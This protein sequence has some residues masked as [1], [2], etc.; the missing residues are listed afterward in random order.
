MPRQN[1][2]DPYGRLIATEARG[3]L[4][5]NR[6]R[7]HDAEGGI[8][9]LWTTRAWIACRLAFKDRHRPPM[10]PGRYTALFF[11]DE[12]TALAAGH[13]PCAE[14]RRDDYLRFKAAWV[15]GN[16][17]LGLT[18]ATPV[19][20]LD[21]ILQRD[22]VAGPPLFTKVFHDAAIDLL[23]DGV[24]IAGTASDEAWLV[25]EDWLLRWSPSGYD[26]AR[27]RPEARTVRVLTPRSIV[28]AIDA[29]YRPRIHDS[30]S[31]LAARAGTPPP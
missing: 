2:V 9:R 17:S 22:R 28:R 15:E 1:R 25:R 30:A 24:F 14:C 13:R 23:P 4:M 21:A 18:R 11:L 27:P 6:G 20:R 8:R 19:Q 12:A 5:G 10:P 29:G 3:T 31:A 26:A 7:L 16:P